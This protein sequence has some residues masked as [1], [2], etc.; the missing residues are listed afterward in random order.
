MA[1]SPLTPGLGWLWLADLQSTLLALLSFLILELLMQ[2]LLRAGLAEAMKQIHALV[3]WVIQSPATNAA[4]YTKPNPGSVR[5]YI[6]WSI[7][8]FLPWNVAL[9]FGVFAWYCTLATILLI[10]QNM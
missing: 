10:L 5:Y 7:E 2:V 9:L 8:A 3:D 4:R 1:V 6:E